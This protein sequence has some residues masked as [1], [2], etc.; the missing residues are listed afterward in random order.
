MRTSIIMQSNVS[1]TPMN[2]LGNSMHE[3][4]APKINFSYSQKRP[5]ISTPKQSGI[6]R[7]YTSDK[8]M[9]LLNK[10]NS[11]P[12]PIKEFT[13]ED[14]KT[15]NGKEEWIRKRVKSNLS[16]KIVRIYTGSY[17]P[18]NGKLNLQTEIDLKKST[19]S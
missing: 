10:L 19:T 8:N 11:Q 3:K 16:K 5:E 9:P 6:M 14:V 18:S 12:N 2:N 15:T 13:L 17:T 7:D 1:N 4:S